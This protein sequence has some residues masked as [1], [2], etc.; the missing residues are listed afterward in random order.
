MARTLRLS[1]VVLAA[2]VA[3]CS[4]D[5]ERTPP[6]PTVDADRS[7]LEAAPGTA[8]ADGVSTVTLIA[9]ARSA[10][11]AAIAG[12][13]A[14]F[15]VTGS[16]NTLSAASATTD[17]GGVA[18]V[19]LTSTRA[20][21]KSA[22][23]VVDGVAVRQVATA[24][25][26]P[27]PAATLS[28][29]GV[30]STATAGQPAAVTVT[31]TDSHGNV[32]TGYR[33]TLHA[34]SSDPAAQ[35]PAD[36]VFAEADAGR[37]TFPVA[38]RTGGAATLTLTDS[39]DDLLTATGSTS[40]A[41]ADAFRLAFASQPADAIAGTLFSP[42]VRV[43]VLDAF[44]NLVTTGS[45]GV[46]LQLQGGTPGALLAGGEASP[47][48]AGVAEF[49]ALSTG[50]AGTG[51]RLVAA[52]PGLLGASS[53]AFDVSAA[54]P[55]AAASSVSA[56]PSLLA[57][58]SESSLSATVRDSCGNPIPG[59]TV[60]FVASGA[61][62][63]INQPGSVTDAA[64]VA[65]GGLS[66]TV[67]ES[68][69]VTAQA[70]GL[71]LST[72][73]IVAFTAG[74]AD[75]A[76][77]SA[78]ASPTSLVADAVAT[79]TITVTLLDAHDNP[80]AGQP[81]T[82]SSSRGL[83]DLLSGWWE[84][85]DAQGRAVF[86][87]RSELAGTSTLTAVVQTGTSATSLSTQVEFLAGPV[88]AS[89]SAVVASPAT[90]NADGASPATV[91]VTL[92]DAKGNP[93]SGKEVSLTSDR[94]AGDAIA[95][96]SGT[97]DAAGDVSFTAVSS[98]F[99]TATFTATDTTDGVT[100]LQTAQVAFA[101]TVS[102]SRST[103]SVSAPS[104]L[105]N[106][107]ASSAITVT[108]VDAFG[109]PV[110]GEPVALA[111]DRGAL[112]AI[113]PA[114]GSTDAAGNVTFTVTSRTF[115]PSTFTATATAYGLS[116]TPTATVTF[117][118]Y[119]VVTTQP[120]ATV[121]AGVAFDPP[122]T[123]TAQD[124]EGNTDAGF[125]AE[126][127][128]ALGTNPSGGTLSG[129]LTAAPSGGIATFADLSLAKAAVG[130]T[131]VASTTAA[132]IPSA[133]SAPFD[134]VPAESAA[135]AFVI[136]P[137][138]AGAGIHPMFQVAVQD[139]F[140]NVVSIDGQE[141]AVTLG[142][143]PSGASLGGLLTAR[144]V[145]GIAT[146]S[147]LSVSLPGA[148]YTLVASD[149][150]G[151][152]SPATSRPF[153]VLAPI[154]IGDGTPGTCTEAAL[155][156]ALA[157]GGHYHFDCGPDP[158]TITLTGT[159]AIARNVGL[160]GGGLVTLSGAGARQLLSIT[161][162]GRTVALE[163]LTITGG[164]TGGNGGAIYGVG[165]LSLWNCTVSGNVATR[166]NDY[167]GTSANGGAIFNNGGTLLIG[168]TTFADNRASSDWGIYG[169]TANGGAIFNAGGKV[170][171]GNATFWGNV[172]SASNSFYGTAGNG[173]AIFNSGGRVW[174]V[175]STLGNN[176]VYSYSNYYGT[177]GQGGAIYGGAMLVNTIVARG[178]SGANCGGPVGGGTNDLDADGTCGVGPATNPMLHA[179][180]LASNGG[181]TQTV[182]LQDGSPAIDAGDP[183]V[184]SAAP[185][186]GLD[187]R[188]YQ[189]PGT[190]ASTCSIG[191]F[192]YASAGPP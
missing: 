51:Y 69:T 150:L 34:T 105:A 41:P 79:S 169:T 187:Q 67:A 101:G 147:G 18:S 36:L 14:T 121:T 93:V 163:G 138:D 154:A 42:S 58:G 11:G 21:A 30:P 156:L 116:L 111:S 176:A 159:K 3:A 129:T 133:T 6:P 185:V 184:C 109:N 104:V 102:P 20:E 82:L 15:E 149:P 37:R 94:G 5:P 123:V 115:G 191:A 76:R 131:L 86:A 192:E 126:V 74:F 97:S 43:S 168:G 26:G 108:V 2:L 75:A 23:V 68:K 95:P 10:S 28:L 151:L 140:G 45:P 167:W 141:V 137:S 46:T 50:T 158:V 54:E 25:F 29:A 70:A 4:S 174:I 60:T 164:T 52:S 189:R 84:T 59:I 55:D 56:Q 27:G 118:S 161:D 99:G 134:V 188:G 145:Y 152:L 53:D 173:G 162:P 73:P 103:L 91:T 100:L 44:G 127:T 48:A 153:D 61:G 160:D 190:G 148:G 77:S 87:I 122:V 136:Q 31:A 170:L 179:A 24:T 63:T 85:T 177:G 130:Y 182:A 183:A 38:W 114:S 90:V 57:V 80:V 128:L 107:S 47:A 157:G 78:V 35:L 106:G 40:V 16:D 181:T 166:A 19:T 1:T 81:V 72:R 119:L 39:V 9:T 22:S 32:A 142:V 165:T 7:T 132:G 89:L 144:T 96:A 178:P 88:S 71:P 172:A 17:A 186:L 139:A 110:A 143:N 65:V 117:L 83:A 98:D 13:V 12:R 171:V 125:S 92:L 146:L 33:G 113:S 49:V 120:P 112:D 66:S 175:N 155:D 64:G 62:N 8:T 124:A 180:G 135:L